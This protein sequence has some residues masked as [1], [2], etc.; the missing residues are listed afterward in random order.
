MAATDFFNVRRDAGTGLGPKR[1]TIH[2]FS[3]TSVDAVY[4][5]FK[6]VLGMMFFLAGVGIWLLPG[7]MDAPETRAMQ[8][9]VTVL[10]V[11]LGYV[12][13]RGGPPKQHPELHIDMVRRTVELGVKDLTGGSVSIAR[14]QMDE[15]SD[16][17]VLGTTV[18]ATD[19]GGNRV[20]SLDLENKSAAAELRDFLIDLPP[21]SNRNNVF[22][23]PGAVF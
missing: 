9:A 23:D 14:Y 3:G 13:F 15:L 22:R 16:I 19:L 18:V 11:G 8:L 5:L 2:T 20:I 1:D 21:L 17:A 12:L 7:A 6:S 4:Y 10:F